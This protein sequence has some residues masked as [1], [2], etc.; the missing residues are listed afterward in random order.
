[1]QRGVPVVTTTTPACA[2]TAGD[3]ALLVE[4]DDVAGLADA[5][6]HVL[7]DGSVHAD[8]AARGRDRARDYSWSATARATLDAYRDAADAVR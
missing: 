3:A 1:M 8:L 2:E 5:L 4:P 6:V 7:T